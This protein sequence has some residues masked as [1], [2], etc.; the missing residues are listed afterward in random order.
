[1]FYIKFYVQTQAGLFFGVWQYAKRQRLEES[2]AVNAA[3]NFEKS[4]K[5]CQYS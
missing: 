1:M 2:T 3:K 5:T 4:P